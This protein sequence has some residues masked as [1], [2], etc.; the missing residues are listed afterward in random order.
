MSKEDEFEQFDEE[1]ETQDTVSYEGLADELPERDVEIPE[2]DEAG[3]RSLSEALEASTDLTDMQYAAAM[4]FPQKLGNLTEN[5][6]MVSRIAPEVF[7]P[8]LHGSVIDE[9]MHSDPSQPLRFEDIKRK[10][11]ALLSIGLDGMG[12]ID[13]A[14]LQGAA[15][16][17][18]IKEKSMGMAI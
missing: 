9:V 16:D 3:A 14:E 15:R 13:M 11:Y 1:L 2:E 7:L 10:H 5:S 18:H 6:L 4:L 12:R 8:L 17:N